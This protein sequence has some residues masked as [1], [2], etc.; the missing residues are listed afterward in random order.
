M[1]KKYEG[2]NRVKRSILQALRKEFEILEMKSGGVSDYFS[3]VMSAANKMRVYGEQIKDSVVVEKILW[4]LSEKFNYIV[5]SIEESKDIDNLSIDELQSS[6]IVH[7]QKFQRNKAEE[8]VLK[9]HH[10]EGT[11]GRGRDRGRTSSRGRGRGCGRGNPTFSKANVKCFKCHNMGHFQYECP[12]WNKESNYSQLNEEEELLLMAHVDEHEAKRNDAW[13]L[14]TGCSNHMCGDRGMFSNLVDDI[15]HFV[16]CGNNTRMLVAEKGNVRLIFNSIHFVVSDLYYTPDLRNILSRVGQLQEK[17]LTI[18]F[19]NEDCNIY[20]PCRGLI[21]HTEMSANRMFILINER[22]K[23]AT[24]I[25]EECLNTSVDSTHL[26]HQQFGHL[27]LKGL[28]T[29]QTKKMVHG[30]PQLG[31]S[32]ITYTDCFTGKQHRNAIPKTSEWHATKVLQLVHADICGPIEPTSHSGKRYVLCFID[33]YSR[34]AWV[35]LIAEKSKALKKFKIFK[36][37]VEKE[38]EEFIKCLRTDRGG[39]FTSLS[40]KAFCEEQ[41]IKRQLTT[42]YTLHQNG[43]A[44]RKNRTV[45][46][47][48][49]CMLTAK[50][51]PKTFWAEAVNWTFHLLNRCPTF[52][53]KNDTPQEAWRGIKPSVERFRIWGCIAHVHIPEAKKK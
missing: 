39:E 11:R 29:L 45:M 3:R 38:V 23:A 50:K 21:A 4:S 32:S 33:D 43:V 12:N 47:M 36:K 30:L 24:S 9:V 5:C 42:A 8:Q 40:F 1:K 46:S 13:F 26:W 17:G 19:K 6:L 34:K 35:Y 48:V 14:D 7:E 52:A 37:L 16:K 18:L 10:E 53:V 41:G 20:Q 28:K 49:R 44:E 31:D 22:S 15:N 27:N 51:V 2:K 25:T